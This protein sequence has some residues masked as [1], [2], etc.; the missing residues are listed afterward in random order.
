MIHYTAACKVRFT[1]YQANK[2]Y[3][4]VG[5]YL[6]EN[7]KGFWIAIGVAVGT[8]V[9]VATDNLAVWVAVGVALGVAM[10]SIPSS[11]ADPKE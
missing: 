9:G 3:S 5:E 11:K 4:C 10:S 8:A 6:M 2:T 7:N 1:Q